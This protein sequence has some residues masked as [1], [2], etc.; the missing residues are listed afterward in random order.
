MKLKLTAIAAFVTLISP[1]HAAIFI[2]S[3]TVSGSGDSD[4][5]IQKA[6]GSLLSG[7]IAA[8]G[9]F[10][11]G[12]SISSNM[13]DIF[14]TLQNFNL[15]TSVSVGGLSTSLG[16]RAPGYFEAEP[17]AGP[18]ITDPSNLIGNQLYLFV[19]D[20]DTLASSTQV[21][22]KQIAKIQ[23]DVPNEQ[24]YLANPK[25]GWLP[26]IGDFGSYIG[27]AS[28]MGSSTY[29][30]LQMEI[31]PLPSYMAL[32]DSSPF[33][34]GS[35]VGGGSYAAGG[36]ATFSATPNAGYLFL[37]WDGDFSGRSNP[38]MYTFSVGS[39]MQ[40]TLTAQFSRDTADDDNDGMGNYDELI[41]YGCDPLQPDSDGDGL[42]DGAEV[43][44][45]GTSPINPDTDGDGLMDGQEVNLFTGY[46]PSKSDTDGDLLPDGLED[47]DGDSLGNLA[48]LNV[49]RTD[50][51]DSDTDNDGLADGFELGAGQFAVVYG[52]FTWLEAS[53]DAIVRGGYL[54]TF[55]T[56]GE[57]EA[58][59]HSLGEE[60]FYDID[61][62]WIGATDSAEEGVWTW[63]TGEP[64]TYTNW[65]PAEPNDF[66]NSDFAA[67]AGELA[68]WLGRW[69]DY[70]G[71]ITRDGYLM[72][73]GYPSD[74]LVSDT[75][76]DGLSDGGEHNL[77]T[78]PHQVDTDGDRLSDFEEV[79][80][81]QTNPLLTDTDA[82][83]VVD[84]N[85]DPDADGLTNFAEVRTYHT[86]PLNLD[87]D[88]DLLSDGQEVTLFGAYDPTRADTDGDNI[89]DGD[90]DFD[91]DGLGNHVEFAVY[92]TDPIKPDT[93]GD[94]LNDSEELVMTSTNPLNPDT[95]GDATSDGNEDPDADE[96]TN[97]DE[98]R[99]HRTN[100]LKP[101]TDGDRLTDSQEAILFMGSYRPFEPDTDGDGISD[102]DEDFDGD[103]L[104]NH[105]ELGVHHTDPLKP[106]TDDDGLSDSEELVIITS[107]PLK[108]DTDGDGIS[109]ASEDADAD[110]LTNLV[111]LRIHHTSPLNRDTNADGVY[112]G[113]AVRLKLNPLEDH[114]DL[115]AIVQ[116]ARKDFGLYS[117]SDVIDL[118]PGSVRLALPT[119]PGGP[120]QLRIKVQRSTDLRTWLEAGEAVYEEPFNSEAYTSNFFRFAWE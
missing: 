72:E 84:A 105:V 45:H 63:L 14:T 18:A 111:E 102:G 109:D 38:F 36:T 24:E 71:T 108:P 107:D 89:S 118:R 37:G 31:I 9:Y 49:H 35:V 56:E 3:N 119:L 75:D 20:G 96:L 99:I 120:L 54:A 74:P 67:V 93:D 53:K 115:L 100:P 13:S 112:D 30:T 116:N 26:V 42:R 91:G 61:G 22:L 21:G 77:R 27:N 57:W 5:L 92:H 40:F 114:K 32:T 88:G 16:L 51:I 62:L 1:L 19:G 39:P 4:A 117:E 87:S 78:N 95:D 101:D 28:G 70:R 90:E 17:F 79:N 52:R 7:G 64:F 47:Y 85:E 104:V 50:P 60:V 11:V 44:T 82:N 97:L 25:G 106:D 34:C 6:D 46:S 103:G 59:L 41:V 86:L 55:A 81:T 8:I 68:G 73:S 94:S 113:L 43:Q 76:G 15:I 65:A 83:G 33:G 66:N 10:P 2:L 58:M 110:G 98:L 23:D 80:A 48:E 29:Q 69:Y 12:Y